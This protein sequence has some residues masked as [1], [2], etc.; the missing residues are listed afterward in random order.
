M[1]GIDISHWQKGIDI[2]KIKADFV[3]AKATEGINFKDECFDSYMAAAVSLGK[4]IGF[5][6]FARPE[7]NSAKAEADFF[8]SVTR[9]Y[10]HRGIPILDWE[11][12]GKSNVAWAKEW[13]DYIYSLTGV[14]PMIYMSQSACNK[15]NWQSV[16][17]ADYGLRIAKYKDMIT[18]KD[19]DMSNAGIK[20]SVK[21]WKFY[22]MWQWTS[23]G[24][25][26]GY[27]KDLDCDVFY[28]TH[29][30]WEKYAGVKRLEYVVCEGDTLTEIAKRYKISIDELVRLNG[31]I[32]TG[33]RLLV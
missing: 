20:P 29:E 24:R 22:A 5:Y 31:L 19:Y 1:N 15:F 11:S 8:Y 18:D 4:S 6:H 2:S 33:K 27:P 25:L 12:A 10:F 3:I 7:K 21:W 26:E 28:G 30:T 23:R 14:K 13:L 17:D 9:E 32:W 16:A